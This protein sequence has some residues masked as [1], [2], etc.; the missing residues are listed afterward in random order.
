MTTN[1]HPLTDRP[2]TT[3]RECTDC[4]A[5]VAAWPEVLCCHCRTV[6]WKRLSTSSQPSTEAVNPGDCYLADRFEWAAPGDRQEDAWLIRFCDKDCREA[7]FTGPDAEREAWEHWNRYAPA[8]NIY[9]FRLAK[10]R[11]SPPLPSGDQRRPIMLEM[12]A[13]DE[14]HQMWER[15]WRAL[16]QMYAPARPC[17]VDRDGDWCLRDFLDYAGQACGFPGNIMD[18]NA[19]FNITKGSPDA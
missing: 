3:D 5:T 9:A 12:A 7:I 4:G 1:P 2:E 11:Q 14:A 18:A 13:A 17:F 15:R 8:F 16:G 19:P 10:L 6:P